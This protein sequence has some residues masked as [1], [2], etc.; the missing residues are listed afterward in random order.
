MNTPKTV[1][2]TKSASAK[3]MLRLLAM[4]ILIPTSLALGVM[5]WNDRQYP[6]VI[7]IITIIGNIPFFLSFERGQ[8]KT[9]RIAVLAVMIALAVAG[10]FL[11]AAI[12][13]FKPVTAIVVISGLCL[14]P[15]AGFMTGSMSALLSNIYFGQG[16]WTPFQM[17]VWGLIGLIA[18]LLSM[19]G[20]LT[21]TIPVCLYG[22]LAGRIYSLLMAIWTVVS[23]DGTFTLAR[24]LAVITASLPTTVIY[25]ISNVL[26]LLLLFQPLSKKLNRLKTKYGI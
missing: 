4:C 26:F 7:L 16:P 14:G 12:P 3:R 15:E 10:R 25:I 19:R 13:G 20:Q 21:K 23:V 6:L 18:G 1:I 24:Y 2:N 11:F 9:R 8:I 5:L 22:A 17:F